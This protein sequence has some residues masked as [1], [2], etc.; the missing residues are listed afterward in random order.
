MSSLV[1]ADSSKPGKALNAALWT[2]QLL[3][4]TGFVIIGWMKLFKPIPELAAMWAWTGQLPPA[5]VRGLGVVDI[6]GGVGI[7]VPAITRIKPGLT[8]LAALG[9]VLLQ[10]AAMTFHMSRGEMAAT[11]V[12]L[13]F[14]ALS[15][16]VWWGRRARPAQAR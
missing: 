6:A 13:I 14:L 2:A 5:V 16:F 3:V 10:I 9:C 4:F 8:V 11:P 1:H 15:A 7:F 12:N